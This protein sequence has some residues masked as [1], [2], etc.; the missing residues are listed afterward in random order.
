MEQIPEEITKKIQYDNRH[1]EVFFL[2]IR[3]KVLNYTLYENL[4]RF[5]TYFE[6]HTEIKVESND[7][8]FF[9]FHAN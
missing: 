4:V 6:D 5:S 7:D 3:I 8:I 2:F 1:K 9:S